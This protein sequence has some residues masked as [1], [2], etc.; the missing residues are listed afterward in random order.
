[1]P[2]MAQARI[3][4]RVKGM[5]CDVPFLTLSFWLRLLFAPKTVFRNN[6]AFRSLC[7]LHLLGCAETNPSSPP[8]T[9]TTRFVATERKHTRV[10]PFLLFFLRVPLYVPISVALGTLQKLRETKLLWEEGNPPAIGIAHACV[11]GDRSRRG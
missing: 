7:S 9:A 10:L 1:M 8:M 5:S 6:V 4:S 2:P 3:K 11:R